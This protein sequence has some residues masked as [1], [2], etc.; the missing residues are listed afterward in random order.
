MDLSILFLFRF[1]GKSPREDVSLMFRSILERELVLDSL[2]DKLLFLFLRETS[3]VE[4]AT[5]K[6]LSALGRR[7]TL[8]L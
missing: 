7:L 8:L 5:V 4:R 3:I 2:G 6:G 1:V